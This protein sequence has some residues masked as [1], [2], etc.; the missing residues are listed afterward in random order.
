MRLLEIMKVL[1]II[2]ATIITK[3]NQILTEIDRIPDFR[4][5]IAFGDE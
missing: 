2:L 5:E 3:I 4:I 1:I